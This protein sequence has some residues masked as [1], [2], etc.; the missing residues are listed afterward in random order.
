MS[1]FLAT[2]SSPPN[3]SLGG[4]VY[5]NARLRRYIC[6]AGLQG[7]FTSNINNNL[8]YS[9]TQ[10]QCINSVGDQICMV[11]GVGESCVSTVQTFFNP[12]T[13][14]Y[15]RIQEYQA[16]WEGHET[17]TDLVCKACKEGRYRGNTDT[18]S[19]LVNVGV[20]CR[21]C[22]AGYFAAGTGYKVC[23]AC[24]TGQYQ[25]SC[26][27][28]DD[29]SN[30]NNDGCV[31]CKNCPS[32]RYQNQTG[33]R[34]CVYCG[35]GKFSSAT[36]AKLPSTC[37]DCVAGSYANDA[38]STACK[39]CPNGWKSDDGA[40]M[41]TICDRGQFAATAGSSTCAL[42]P[43]GQIASSSGLSS[44]SPCTSGKET[45]KKQEQG[46]A[47][48]VPC[49]EGTHEANHLCVDCPVGWNQEQKGTSACLE[50]PVGRVA[51]ANKT[52]AECTACLKSQ[53]QSS[54][55]QTSCLNCLAGFYTDQSA[56]SSCDGC[57]KGYSASDNVALCTPCATGQFQSNEE[58]ASCIN[59]DKGRY[60]DVTGLPT[61]KMCGAD[62][63]SEP[64]GGLKSYQNVTGQTTCKWCPNA[65]ET[66]SASRDSCT[67]CASN[68]AFGPNSYADSGGTCRICQ[69]C[70]LGSFKSECSGTA[71]CK[72]CPAGTYKSTD[73]T[74]VNNPQDLGTGWDAVC[75]DC[76]SCPAGKY[77][78]SSDAC[79]SSGSG[80]D[81]VENCLDCAYDTFKVS[82]GT[83]D[84]VC[85]PCVA[86]P[87][88]ATK[89]SCGLANAGTCAA[90]SQPTVTSV[91]GSGKNGGDTQGDE[92]LH[93]Y[94][95][96]FG[97]VRAGSNAVDV[98]VRYGPQDPPTQYTAKSCEVVRAGDG[99]LAGHI[100]CYTAAGV[101]K[102]HALNVQI[103]NFN[104]APLVSETF[105]AGITYAA[106]IVAV[107]SGSGADNAIT[108]GGQTLIIT[109]TQFGPLGT[110][111][112]NATYGDN[113]YQLQ[114]DVSTCS[115]TVAHK[116]ITCLTTQGAGKGLKLILEI[117]GQFST[118]PAIN[119]GAPQLKQQKCVAAAD[120]GKYLE[121]T[122][123]CGCD[124]CPFLVV[125]GQNTVPAITVGDGSCWLKDGKPSCAGGQPTPVA[126]DFNGAARLATSG[127]QLI[128]LS[129]K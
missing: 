35:K 23:D 48:C 66:A 42:C 10:S 11:T 43:T 56:Q 6:Y 1:P 77:R 107:Y 60:A 72:Y 58:Q 88:G 15:P 12:A 20:S 41:C 5:C 118:I 2:P 94:G 110:A 25:T 100:R 70:P 85:T 30:G 81:G 105:N 63:T 39:Q 4:S 27:Q 120:N 28:E 49:D 37:T 73:Q 87:I 26:S 99:L 116:E 84:A 8:D 21:S 52:T 75:T 19:H 104:N 124:R 83:F 71:A 64:N 91:D 80:T 112:Q 45:D 51:A 18:D 3:C 44:C 40:Q 95:T 53:Y 108:S 90:W 62:G 9:Y 22:P 59:C 57:P 97:F 50:C 32:G 74:G 78:G 34:V 69:G 106:P 61:C 122:T 125:D 13:R 119:Y 79:L 36:A 103:G 109:G 54:T 82:N 111:I 76:S 126:N 98:V 31:R 121:S 55:R 101:G 123:F 38:G 46:G 16:C 33:A 67:T 24:E 127:G 89:M 14:T 29:D 115:V 47:S 114:M 96:H 128:L 117:G 93:I 17:G 129:G 86:C 102:N 65:G 68:P 92:V 7:H 113:N